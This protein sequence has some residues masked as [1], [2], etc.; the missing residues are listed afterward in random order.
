MPSL[1]DSFGAPSKKEED[2][3]FWSDAYEVGRQVGA[4]FAVDLPRMVGQG[5][6]RVAPDGSSLDEFGRSVVESADERA[7]GWEPDLRGRGTFAETLIKGGRAVGPMAPGI[8]AMAVPGGGALLGAAATGGLFGFSQAQDTEDKLR[9]Q[10]VPNDEATPAGIWTGG[11]QGLGEAGATYLGA[12]A[13]GL[14]RPLLPA[15]LGGG[16]Q[17]MGGVVGSMTNQSVLKP[18]AKG[19]A[20]NFA[21]QPVTEIGQD[22]GTELVERGYGAQ[23]QDAWEIA[24]DSAQ[25]A[26]GLT[27]LLGPL[28][29]FGNVRRA[30]AAKQLDAALAFP[31]AKIRAQA[32]DIVVREAR[33]QGVDA[34][35]IAEWLTARQ[36]AFARREQAASEAIDLLQKPQPDF[37]SVDTNTGIVGAFNPYDLG[38]YVS[39]FQRGADTVAT[40]QFGLFSGVPEQTFT[41]AQQ[42]PLS[43]GGAM[44]DALAR[45]G[46]WAETNVEDANPSM[47]PGVYAPRNTKLDLP[48]VDSVKSTR[49]QPVAKKAEKQFARYVQQVGDSKKRA[50]S[51]VDELDRLVESGQVT[52]NERDTMF[53]SIRDAQD[54]PAAYK[55]VE[56][57]IVSR[58]MPAP[59][60]AAPQK[61]PQILVAPSTKPD[62]GNQLLV[63]E[64]PNVSVPDVPGPG[65]GVGSD[66]GGVVDAG[67][68]A[69]PGRVPAAADGVRGVPD[70]VRAPA[71][72]PAVDGVG[73]PSAPA[74]VPSRRAQITRTVKEQQLV[75]E[76]AKERRAVLGG[77][78]D[79]KAVKDILEPVDPRLHHAVRLALGVDAQ[80][81]RLDKGLTNQQAAA[82]AGLG[83]NSGS[84]VSNAMKALGLTMQVRRK[85][86]SSN[87]QANERA[88]GLDETPPK[89][90]AEEAAQEATSIIVAEPDSTADSD[91]AV[92]SEKKG[93]KF[94]GKTESKKVTAPLASRARYRAAVEI[95]FDKLSDAQLADLYIFSQPF[96]EKNAAQDRAALQTIVTELRR[97]EKSPSFRKA[98]EDAFEKAAPDT[99]RGEP[100]AEQAD[101]EDDNQYSVQ[102]RRSDKRDVMHTAETLE[103]A[104]T[105]F[106]RSD[107][108]G[109]RV[110]VVDTVGDLA[111]YLPKAA[112]D[113][114]I[115]KEKSGK[116]PV[117]FARDGTAYLIADRMRV[118]AERGIFL[119]EVGGHL[120]MERLLPGEKFTNVAR[121]ILSWSKREGDGL[122]TALAKRAVAR[123]KAAEVGKG[124]G[125]SE[126]VAYFLEESV[127]SGINP[128]AAKADGPLGAMLRTIWHAFKVAL[129]KLGVK[130]DTLTPQDIID[131]GYGAARIN[132]TGKWH[133][134]AAN[135]HQFKNDYMGSGEGGRIIGWGQYFS[136][137]RGVGENYRDSDVRRKKAKGINVA[138]NLYTADFNI[139]DDEWLDWSRLVDEQSGRV[140][141]I[142]T[143]GQ[144]AD[145]VSEAED[146]SGGNVDGEALYKYLKTVAGE[147][148]LPDEHLSKADKQRYADGNLPEDEAVSKYLDSIGIKGIRY[149][150]NSTRG[151]TYE[152]GTN[153]VVFNDKNILRVLNNPENNTSEESQFSEQLDE[154][155]RTPIPDRTLADL[156]PEYADLKGK[157]LSYE[158]RVAE[159]GE[160]ATMTADAQDMMRELDE[161]ESLMKSIIDCLKK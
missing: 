139:A 148:G 29:L 16:A 130:I 159:T 84:R 73:Q 56:K 119:H 13:L 8:A 6:R 31:D 27:A 32:E 114:L 122:E 10:G 92:G 66:A 138:G 51:V 21:L 150:V 18:F 53:A 94:A 44:G 86:L 49:G 38:G 2:R 80:S 157:K 34:G 17:T 57:F 109:K 45:A 76:R 25:G 7:P 112:I 81:D 42:P 154:E 52:E 128:T 149:P 3:P 89:S 151:G 61:Q 87:A 113:E 136:Q 104:L 82:R 88:E 41:E 20:A 63:G 5:L 124:Q 99:T 135:V 144:F 153:F 60:P 74:V 22:V 102:D 4:G 133:G 33:A 85:W 15:W 147:G 39:D 30:S 160:T 9:L 121:Q 70:G 125:A 72:A 43:D 12:K 83:E 140:Q 54:K 64:Q 26:I 98:L 93:A 120:G 106:M 131:L 141:G 69:A 62:V 110:I 75:A 152:D 95:G 78:I 123:V 111:K 35:S 117:A 116:K 161:R 108:L 101:N 129:R 115:A 156:G 14:A 71:A 105:A 91:E 67:G 58:S 50:R 97:R 55:A 19:M 11:I 28:A 158:V 126:L 59:A 68:V 100:P 90:F 40:P 37:S 107:T 146:W 118:G 36:E 96:V 127:N 155:I 79:W 48:A 77:D 137:L 1:F 132:V 143:T 47:T 103:D 24:K 46:L 142:L 145:W 23:P 134:T 65:A